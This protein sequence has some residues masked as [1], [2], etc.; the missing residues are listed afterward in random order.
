MKRDK[1]VS[2]CM[3]ICM[4]KLRKFVLIVIVFFYSQSVTRHREMCFAN[5]NKKV[6]SFIFNYV[7]QFKYII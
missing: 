4:C 7:Q 5:I 6:R 3:L 2:G 1:W